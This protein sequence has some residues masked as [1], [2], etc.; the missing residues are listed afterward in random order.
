MQD[1][2]VDWDRGYLLMSV[3]AAARNSPVATTRDWI[4]RLRNLE[5]S[6]NGTDLTAGARRSMSFSIYNPSGAA[7]AVSQKKRTLS[8]TSM[9]MEEDITVK[10][11]AQKQI[12]RE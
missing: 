8:E 6:R 10:R 3:A 7:V 5:P 2:A 9:D 4:H 1:Y 11:P 12:K